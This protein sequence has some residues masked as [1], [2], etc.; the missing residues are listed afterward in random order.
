M[1][2]VKNVKTTWFIFCEDAHSNE[3][4]STTLDG[5]QS[6]S[7]FSLMECVDGVKRHLY[8]VTGY[9]VASRLFKSQKQLKAKL[10]IFRSQNDGKPA[11]WEFIVKKKPT[12]NQLKKK[13]DRIKLGATMPQH[14]AH[15]N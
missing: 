14:R 13:S 3:V 8:R 2:T 6:N 9:S 5:A 15:K 10:Q 1:P 4:V 11:V 12:L 7:E